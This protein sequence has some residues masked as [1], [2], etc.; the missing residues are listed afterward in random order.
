MESDKATWTGGPLLLTTQS[1]NPWHTFRYD[2]SFNTCWGYFCEMAYPIDS[3]SSKYSTLLNI[4]SVHVR[5]QR[6]FD[7]K[8]ITRSIEH[9]CN[10]VLA[11]YHVSYDYAKKRNDIAKYGYACK[12]VA[13]AIVAYS[14][15]IHYQLATKGNLGEVSLERSQGELK[16]I[17]DINFKGM[18]FNDLRDIVRHLVLGTIKR[19]YYCSN[20]SEL[21]VGIKE[22][23]TDKDVEDFL[24]I[25]YKN[26]C[27]EYY[28]SDGVEE[29]D[30]VD[31][32]TEGKENVVIKN[33]TTQDPFLNKLFSNHGSFRGLIDEPVHV[34]Q[35]P[36]DDPDD[37]SI[38]PL[39][40]YGR[41]VEAGR[42]ENK[43]NPPNKSMLGKK[44]EATNKPMTPVKKGRPVKKGKPVKK[45]VSFSPN[46]TTRSL[47]S[48]EGYSR[49]GEGDAEKSP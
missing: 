10:E 35:E 6:P 42:Y 36:I 26:K 2:V 44:S 39:Y 18:S 30:Y 46:V 13:S 28:S 15:K 20:K 12:V 17:R 48:G 1:Q 21:D 11:I 22:L 31:F 43:S 25:G 38:D 47:N 34:D 40:E 41:N 9:V 7:F 5:S 29:L 45:S 33:L 14:Q 4:P 37:A 3:L 16:Q 8:D 24:R 49:D 23:K 32:H 27:D 19:L